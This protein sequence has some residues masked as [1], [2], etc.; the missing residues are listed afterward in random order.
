MGAALPYPPGWRR[1]RSD[2]G[3]ATAAA[4]GNDGRYIG[5]LNLT[6]RQGGETLS[7]WARFRVAH[8]ADEHE[9]NVTRLAAATRLRFGSGTGSCLRDTYTTTTGAQYVELACLVAGRKASVVVVGASPPQAWGK[10]AP[11]IER[12]ISSVTA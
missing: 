12:A 9:R 6:P 1:I 3:T 11:L 7:N 8:N 4:F 5:Y 10:I 2:P